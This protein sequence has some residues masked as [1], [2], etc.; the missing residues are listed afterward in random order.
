MLIT[1]EIDELNKTKLH[2]NLKTKE[3]NSKSILSP[4]TALGDGRWRHD[5]DV[6]R[7]RLLDHGRQ[8]RAQR[9]HQSG[10]G[11]GRRS[12]GGG[13]EAP[14]AAAP[15]AAPGRSLWGTFAGRGRNGRWG[16]VQRGSSR[17]R[18]AGP[19]GVLKSGERGGRWWPVVRR[20]RGKRNYMKSIIDTQKSHTH[21][22]THIKATDLTLFAPE[23]EAGE[24]VW[25]ELVS[26]GKRYISKR[27]LSK[28]KTALVFS[29][30]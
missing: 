18:I 10:P 5:A 26:G 24:C 23:V 9:A 15:P 11:T 19:H 22:H 8:G 4:P 2:K 7:G 13:G 14:D 12:A 6:R 3:K 30:D 1:I 29:L 17:G 20:W 21:T 25:S 16:R 27:I 28:Y